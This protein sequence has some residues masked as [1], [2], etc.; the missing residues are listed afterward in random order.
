[1]WTGGGEG[2][3]AYVDVHKWGGARRKNRPKNGRKLAAKLQKKRPKIAWKVA[4]LA[5]THSF[6]PDCYRYAPKG[7]GA[8]VY[9]F[10][11]LK[12]ALRRSLMLDVDVW[13]GGGIGRM[14]TGK[15]GQKSRFFVDVINGWPLKA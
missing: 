6:S 12:C 11:S 9:R 1:M 7:D 14:W 5:K 8:P 13:G 4:V 2:V 15:G 10:I 3:R